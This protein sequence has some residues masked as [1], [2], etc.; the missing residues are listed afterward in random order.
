MTDDAP[1]FEPLSSLFHGDRERMRRTLE[2]FLQVVRTDGERLEAAFAGQDW[3]EIG[4]L[5]HRLKSSLRQIGEYAA[6]EAAVAMEAALA[7]HVAGEAD[8]RTTALRAVREELVQV[9]QRVA[10]YLATEN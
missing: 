6:A 4:R 1:A 3:A 9:E 8:A 10:R 2:V 5:M 7:G